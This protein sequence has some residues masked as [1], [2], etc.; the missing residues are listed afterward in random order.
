MIIYHKT[1]V[2][3]SFE[4]GVRGLRGKAARCIFV[5]KNNPAVLEAGISLRNLRSLGAF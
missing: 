1:K 4:T 2:Q 3:N 5:H